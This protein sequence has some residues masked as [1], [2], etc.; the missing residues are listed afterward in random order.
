MRF[1]PQSRNSEREQI[2]VEHHLIH[3]DAFLDVIVPKYVQRQYQS[4]SQ[5]E[6]IECLKR[7]DQTNRNCLH[8]I[9][10]IQTLSSMEDAFDSNESER[11]RD[12]LLDNSTLLTIDNALDYFDYRKYVKHLSP[13]RHRIYF[14]LGNQSQ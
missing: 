3:F 11:L 7:L 9:V 8:K 2:D 4:A 6:L 10:F 13:E 5:T 1:H 14:D 12:F